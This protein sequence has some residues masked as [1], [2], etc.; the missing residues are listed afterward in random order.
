[1]PPKKQEPKKVEAQ[2]IAEVAKDVI[3]VL[4]EEEGFSLSNVVRL[5]IVAYQ[6]VE[7]VDAF[8]LP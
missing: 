5:I 6:K 7:H 1:M 8:S 2:E 3:L 4:E